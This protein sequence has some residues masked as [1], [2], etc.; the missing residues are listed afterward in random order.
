MITPAS[1]PEA[2]KQL[3]PNCLMT[4]SRIDKKGFESL[5]RLVKATQCYWLD[6]GDDLD[7]VPQLVREVVER[8]A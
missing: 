4:A 2:L 7:R 8:D 3:A 1:K 5:V 6:L